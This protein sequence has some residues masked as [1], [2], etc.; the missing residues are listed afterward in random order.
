MSRPRHA[1]A[2]SPF[3]VGGALALASAVAFGVSTPLVQ[4]F[5]RGVGPFATAAPLYG[6]P[7]IAA[8]SRHV[9]LAKSALGAVLSLAL[10]YA[11]REPPPTWTVAASLAACGAVGYGAS[12]RLYL[13]AQRIAGAARTGSVFAAAPFLGA[14]VA[15]AMGERG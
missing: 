1:A 8:A 3:A 13:L 4:R 5:G 11:V 7:A 14:A 15:W 10:A 12:L 2:R 9:V 6:G